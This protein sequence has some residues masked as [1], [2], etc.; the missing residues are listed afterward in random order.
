[1]NLRSVA[2]FLGNLVM[3]LAAAMLIPA[4]VAWY[5]GEGEVG[6]F[7]YSACVAAGVGAAVSYGFRQ[8]KELSLTRQD[9]FL[10]VTGAWIAASLTGALPYIFIKGAGFF[11]NG[12][13]ETAS[14]FT[15]TG[16]SILPNV[17]SEAQSLLLWRA[18]TQ[19]LGGMGIIVLA[20]AILP[21]L[22][23]GGMDLLSAEM[24]GPSQEKLTPRIAQTAKLLWGIY[25]LLTASETVILMILGMPFLD[26]LAH[27]F[28]TLATGG[29]S[30]RNLSI[31]AYGAATQ[32]VVTLFMVLG[33]TNFALHYHVLKRNVGRLFHD[34]EFRWYIGIL[35]V[36]AIL[37][38]I[39]L[40]SAGVSHDF[41]EAI[42]LGAFQ[43]TSIMTC[44]GFASADFDKW[45]E[46][47]RQLLFLLMFIGGCAGSTTGSIKVVRIIIALK[48]EVRAAKLLLSPN[49]VLPITLGE[50]RVSD[51]IVDA[52]I[53]F[54]TLY[55]ITFLV[56][57]VALIF[58][59][60]DPESALSAS[61]TCL[62]TI[63]P[64]LGA[65]GPARTFLELPDMGKLV[66]VAEMI[67]GRLELYTALIVPI[68]LWRRKG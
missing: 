56:G 13:F 28:A 21:K 23:V 31:G 53:S 60:L 24:P 39:N 57:G 47:S 36:A 3:V 18:L 2:F 43:V 30:T 63:G 65:V 1:M 55:I 58:L 41:G 37:V 33:A 7:L 38:A 61:A 49:A 62:G 8:Q 9:G 14:G 48:A 6:A 32:W 44:T 5:L 12:L 15:A 26:A 20:L 29:F 51:A 67:L 34:I 68:L 10:L 50:H 4:G 22:A 19:W 66:L 52:V 40:L 64:G 42:R 16:A 45:P 11:I 25:V 46:F 17:E 27:S 35:S 59:G 54:I